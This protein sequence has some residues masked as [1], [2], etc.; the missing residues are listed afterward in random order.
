[1]NDNFGWGTSLRCFYIP[2]TE[3]GTVGEKKS[4]GFYS[5]TFLTLNF[6]YNFLAGYNFKGLTI[7][8]NLKMGIRSMP[9]IAGITEE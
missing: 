2:F 9:P 5:E 4:S 7:G 8:G 3:Y 6:A 1:R